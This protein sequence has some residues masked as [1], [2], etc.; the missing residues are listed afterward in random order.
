MK[1]SAATSTSTSIGPR[2][3]PLLATLSSLSRRI[4]DL[5]TF[6]IETTEMRESV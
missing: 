6:D 3:N 2:Q 1:A 4:I 5:S